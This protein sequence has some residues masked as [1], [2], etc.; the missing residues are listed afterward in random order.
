MSITEFTIKSGHDTQFREGV[1]AWKTC[2]LENDGEWEWNMWRRVQGEGIVYGLTS[3]MNHWAEMDDEDEAGAACQSLA[4]SMIVPHI[5]S[6]VRNMSRT[7]PDISKAPSEAMEVASVFYWRVKN[8]TKFMNTVR[9][10]ESA[11]RKVE[12]EPRGYWHSSIGGDLN[13]PHYFVVTPYADFAAMDT[14]MDSV[15]DVVEK[16]DGKK[17]RDQLQADYRESLEQS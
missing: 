13:A 12:G 2:Y 16:A 7:M 5:K 9:S 14:P 11:L 1:S 17:K 8:G 15:W 3:F 6:S 4:Q 10:V